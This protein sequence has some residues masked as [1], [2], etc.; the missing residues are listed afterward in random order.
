MLVL[1][2]SHIGKNLTQNGEPQI[3]SWELCRRRRRLMR[4]VIFTVWVTCELGLCRWCFRLCWWLVNLDCAGGVA[5]CAGDVCSEGHTGGDQDPSAG[6]HADRAAHVRLHGTGQSA[7]FT[8]YFIWAFVCLFCGGGGGREGLFCFV[9][10][11]LLP[12]RRRSGH[13]KWLKFL[14]QVGAMSV[15]PAWQ[16]LQGQFWETWEQRQSS[17]AHSE[18]NNATLS[19]VWNLVLSGSVRL[20]WC[21]KRSAPYS[22]R[23]ESKQRSESVHA[24]M[25]STAKPQKILTFIS[26]MGECQQQKLTQCDYR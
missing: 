24:C 8:F 10:L 14:P 1:K 15:H 20:G 23:C 16:L 21:G 19:R 17:H 22:F 12:Y 6:P 26:Q 4:Q 25:H 3:Y 9:M 11:C 5:V 2:N 13:E 7:S 18:C